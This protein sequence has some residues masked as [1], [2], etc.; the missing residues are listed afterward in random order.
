MTTIYILR[1]QGGRYYIGRS[2]N[3][4]QR[5]RQHV[6]GNGS[7]WTHKYPPIEITKL[8]PNASPFDEDRYVKEYVAIHGIQNVRG[9]SYSSIVLTGEQKR[10]LESEIRGAT[11][12][13]MKCGMKGHFAAN[14]YARV[15]APGGEGEDPRPTRAAVRRF[16]VLSARARASAPPPAP[17]ANCYARTTVYISSDSESE[18]E[19]ECNYCDHTF[20]SQLECADHERRCGKKNVCYRCGRDSH[21]SPDCY[22]SRHVD[23]SRLD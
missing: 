3:P 19:W 2:D 11:D 16:G 21:Y 1:L 5:F 18:D 15:Q 17:A 7:A 12:A 10:A 6:A 23:G 9:G 22:A 8:V 4:H 14:C 13:C 20:R